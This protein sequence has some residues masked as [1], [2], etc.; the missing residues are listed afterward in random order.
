MSYAIKVTDQNDKEHILAI[1]KKVL[2]T[3]FYF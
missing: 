1:D 3:F 2:M